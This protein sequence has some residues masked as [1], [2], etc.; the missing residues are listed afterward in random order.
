MRWFPATR[1]DLGMG[2]ASKILTVTE[3]TEANFF[4]RTG[5]EFIPTDFCGNELKSCA[6]ELRFCEPNLIPVQKSEPLWLLYTVQ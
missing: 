3:A 2:G 5:S 4:R 1:K 6:G